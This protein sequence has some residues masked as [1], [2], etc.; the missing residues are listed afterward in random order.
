M[1]YLGELRQNIRPLVA[2]SLG[3]G[4][5]LPLFAF[6]NSVFAP[7]IIQA[8]GWS[9]AQFALIGITMLL[10]LPFLPWIG[11]LTDKHGV[12]K[13]ALAGTLLVLPCFIGFSL[14]QGDFTLYLILF[15]A[16]LIVASATGQLVYGRVIAEKFQKA[17]GLAFTIVLCAP[18]V[19]AIPISPMLNLVIE[20]IGWRTAYL[21][22]GTFC[23]V[24]GLIAV[25][26]IEPHKAKDQPEGEI[27]IPFE[28]TARRDYGII[29]RSRVFWIITAAMFLCLLQTQLHASQMNLMLIDQG[30]TMQMAA[31]IVPIYAAGTLVGRI[32][33]GVA[34]DHF[35][36]PI[37]TFCSMILPAFGFFVLGTSL[38]SYM[39]IAS[40]MFLIGMAVGAESDLIS[41]LVARY[42]KIRIYNSTLGLVMTASFLSSATG[43]LGVSFTLK[44]YDSFE[45]FLFVIAG[46][47]LLGSLLF[48]LLPKS[49]E[50]EK[51]G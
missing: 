28:G 25:W 49:R 46:S 11:R 4:T 39:V 5:S 2:A 10:T 38:D 7:H 12:R 36:T 43:A 15:T 29:L 35:S 9:R 27:A 1:S 32:A 48:L 34:L 33:C 23:F 6:T 42:F 47:I 45:P 44:R 24:C 19:L 30:L 37:V 40:A 31:N 18:A 17:Q 8:F 22:L 20:T 16:L 50:A 13:V 26:L 3:V 41:F 14:M 21:M 51:V